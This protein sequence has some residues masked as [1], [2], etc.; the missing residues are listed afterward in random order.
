MRLLGLFARRE[1]GVDHRA[2]FRGFAESLARLA[3][4]AAP[5]IRQPGS[6]ASPFCRAQTRRCP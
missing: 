4:H 5:A 2:V 1:A 6:A 3:G